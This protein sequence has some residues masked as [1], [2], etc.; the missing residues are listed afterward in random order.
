MGYIIG[1]LCILTGHRSIV[2]T[3]MTKENVVNCDIWNHGK[4]FLVLEDDHKTVRSFGQ[5]VFSLNEEEF[6]WLENLT[7][8]KCCPQ[9]QASD[10][11]FHTTLGKQIGQA[12]NFLSLAWA[13]CG[14]K[15]TIFNKALTRS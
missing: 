13:D 6:R 1:Y 14:M 7:N 3:N 8:C 5:A 15:G 4:R 10:Y 12:G 9:G 11:V 2:F